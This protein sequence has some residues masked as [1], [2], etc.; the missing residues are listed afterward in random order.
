MG[1]GGWCRSW[2]KSWL[3]PPSESIDRRKDHGQ[4]RW[5]RVRL[6]DSVIKCSQGRKRSAVGGVQHGEYGEWVWEMENQSA[7]LNEKQGNWE[8]N[9]LGTKAGVL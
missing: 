2:G 9:S 1:L 3:C 8:A 5:R 7:E 4:G 6:P